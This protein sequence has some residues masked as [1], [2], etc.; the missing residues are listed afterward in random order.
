MRMALHYDVAQALRFAYRNNMVE[1][2]QCLEKFEQ[3]KSR[4][5]DAER[6]SDHRRGSPTWSRRYLD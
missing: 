1:I 5:K 4:L 3:D 6:T 2:A